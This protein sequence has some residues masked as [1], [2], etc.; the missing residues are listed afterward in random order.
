MLAQP[1]LASLP[2]LPLALGAGVG[3][4]VSAAY[5][6]AVWVPVLGVLALVALLAL[7]VAR[8]RFSH[9]SWGYWAYALSG[10]A[11]A[12]VAAE[13]WQLQQPASQP[14]HA[15]H[16]ISKHGAAFSGYVFT[17]ESA[18]PTRK[19]V[20]LKGEI[21]KL[22]SPG[23]QALNTHGAARVWMPATSVEYH[24]GDHLLIAGVPDTLQPGKALAGMDFDT[25]FAHQGYYLT[26]FLRSAQ[27]V[28]VLHRASNYHPMRLVERVRQAVERRLL[29]SIGTAPEAAVGVALLLGLRHHVSPETNQAYASAGTLHALAVSGMHVVYLFT[30]FW[31]AT[32]WVPLRWQGPGRLYRSLGVLG[33]VWA[34]VALTGFQPSIVRAAVVF[35]LMQAGK[36]V[37]RQSGALN[38]LLAAFCLLLIYRPGYLFDIGFQ[39]SFAAVGGILLFMPWLEARLITKTWLTRS[40][41]QG[42]CLTLAAQAGATL[43]SL[44]H[45]HQFPAYFLLSNLPVGVLSAAAMAGL[46]ATVALWWVPMLGP[47]I[48]HI[49]QSVVWLLNQ[50]MVQVSSLPGALVQPIALTWAEACWLAMLG[51]AGFAYLT[52]RHLAVL[53]LVAALAAIWGI[54]Q[55]ATLV[56]TAGRHQLFVMANGAL[57]QQQ[58]LRM[59]QWGASAADAQVAMAGL[60]LVKKYPHELDP[61]AA[62]QLLIAQNRMGNILHITL[63]PKRLKPWRPAPPATP[64]VLTLSDRSLS[65]IY[66]TI[67]NLKRARLLGIPLP[68][69]DDQ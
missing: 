55:S 43:V 13:A 68:A 11:M 22:I 69:L 30:L 60:V 18:N 9:T 53:K 1:K 61:A 51:L 8:K 66:P 45:F 35:S 44:V 54:W 20:T 33:L 26:H 37:Y 42:V 4:G 14:K 12:G 40:L 24:Y 57:A 3:A 34:F 47:L 32:R 48:G 65:N 31:W 41:W 56:H 64:W 67:T 5:P 58:G 19:G 29:S 52:S 16:A 28:A 38:G 59:A 36:V 17:V 7:W 39:L 49:T 10:L 50:T 2:F 62:N 6:Q 25:Y 15:L 63:L 21:T 27:G 23:G 46:A